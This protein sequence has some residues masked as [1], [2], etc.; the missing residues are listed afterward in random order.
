MSRQTRE[1]RD[2]NLH[3]LSNFER[4]CAEKIEAFLPTVIAE[5]QK[6]HN[7]GWNSCGSNKGL[8][9]PI[10][11]SQI[12]DATKLRADG[13][14]WKECIRVTKIQQDKIQKIVTDY[15]KSKGIKLPSNKRGKKEG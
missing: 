13:K 8:R 1:G 10:L 9:R 4:E 7:K 11:H 6:E 2:L 12:V 14:S 15:A 3:C 5:G